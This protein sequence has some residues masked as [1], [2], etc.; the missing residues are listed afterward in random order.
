MRAKSKAA[1][2][3][4]LQIEC[5]AKSPAYRNHT[6]IP[7]ATRPQSSGMRVTN[8][9][10]ARCDEFFAGVLPFSLIL[11]AAASPA[12]AAGCSFEPQ[13]E[14]RVAEIIDARSF[15]LQ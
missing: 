2:G 3:V 5:C 13:G 12:V 9:L 11:I 4:V 15:R 6:R 14:G 8:R 1:C 10:A 7:P